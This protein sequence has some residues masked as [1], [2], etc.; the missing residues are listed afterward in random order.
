TIHVNGG[1]DVELTVRSSVHGPIVSDV[2]DL[3]GVADVPVPDG[4]PG[5]TYVHHFQ[6][7]LYRPSA[8]TS[9][10]ALILIKGLAAG[11]DQVFKGPFLKPVLQ[12]MVKGAVTDE[13][14]AVNR[15][16]MEIIFDEFMNYFSL[17]K[18]TAQD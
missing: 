17:R 9:I 3:D 12:T 4:S 8:Y 13:G 7:G 14:I 15:H 1:D 11:L 5:G 18:Y 16:L 6:V 2:L 10:N